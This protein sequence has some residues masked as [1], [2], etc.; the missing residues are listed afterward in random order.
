MFG[1]VQAH[2]NSPI[3]NNF[4]FDLGCS[5]TCNIFSNQHLSIGINT[6]LFLIDLDFVRIKLI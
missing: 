6:D 4:M 5:F 2:Y 1:H 3:E